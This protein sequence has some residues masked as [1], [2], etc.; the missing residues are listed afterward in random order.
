VVDVGM[1]GTSLMTG[2]F[3]GGLVSGA[4]SLF[5]TAAPENL[6]INGIPIAGET[7]KAGPMKELTF[8]FVVL[9]R[10]VDFLEMIL[11]RTHADRSIAELPETNL[12]E[13]INHL[14]KVDQVQLTRLLQK[15]HKGLSE[16]ELIKL[17]DWVLALCL[18]SEA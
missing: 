4:A 11:R 8:I 2:A 18:S 14:P 13:R 10:A 12:T 9:G 5:A 6:K 17:R 16:A 3:F 7:L 1:G 15:A